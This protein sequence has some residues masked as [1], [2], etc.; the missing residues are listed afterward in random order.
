MRKREGEEK[1]RKKA[2]I[3]TR[4]YRKRK[5]GGGG[6]GEGAGKGERKNRMGRAAPL[7]GTGVGARAG[8]R[9]FLYRGASGPRAAD[10]LAP[11]RRQRRPFFFLL[12][13]LP[14][15]LGGLSSCVRWRPRASHHART[16]RICT[17]ARLVLCP[18]WYRQ[19]RRRH[20]PI[21]HRIGVLLAGD[22]FTTSLECSGVPDFYHCELML[23]LE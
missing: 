17:R 3:D 6:G 23:H 22:F 8:R 12:L 20:G 10:F 13:L 21:V 14:H 11:R 18:L 16:T 7:E 15:L 2:R 4:V 1:K 19:H 9:R 5:D